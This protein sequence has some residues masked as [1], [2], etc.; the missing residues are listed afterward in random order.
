MAKNDVEQGSIL[1]IKASSLWWSLLEELR[2]ERD[3]LK[4]WKRLPN[5][6]T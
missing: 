5:N 1:A 6:C 2:A 4:H 3:V